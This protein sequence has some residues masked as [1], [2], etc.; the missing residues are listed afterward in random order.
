M[1]KKLIINKIKVF[2]IINL[3]LLSFSMLLF[4]LNNSMIF[5]EEPTKISKSSQFVIEEFI[6]KDISKDIYKIKIKV[7]KS[8][9][10]VESLTGTK[11]K[12]YTFEIG[13]SKAVYIN[14]SAKINLQDQNN[15]E[16]LIKTKQKIDSG[17][18]VFNIYSYKNEDQL[19]L[20]ATK[21]IE[22]PNRNSSPGKQPFIQV[23]NP[24]AG[25]SS[26][27]ITVVGENFGNDLDLI[28][29]SFGEIN[30]KE[31]EG[32]VDVAERKP[33]FLSPILNGS[34][35][36]LKFN[37]PSAK[38]IPNSFLFKQNL[39][40][41]IFVNGRPSDYKKLVILSDY[42]K[43][44]MLGFTVSLISIFHLFIIK[45]LKKK[46]YLSLLL[47]DKSTN[48]Y[49]LSRFQAFS[50]T[51]LLLGGYFY[52]TI[53]SGVLLGNG[54]IPEFNP[55]LIGLLSISYG[56]L[57]TAH[58]L[59][60]KKPKNEILKTPPLFNNLFSSGE[61][62][63]LPRL[64]LFSFTVVGIIIYLYNL[65]NSNPL[66]GLPDIPS[67]FL[68]L[69]GVSQTGYITGKF[70]S[71][72]IVI[73]QIKP[74]YIPVNQKDLRLH[75]LGAG[76]VQNMKILLDDLNEPISVDF[77]NSN[78]I[79]FLLPERTN[80]GFLSIN[81]LHNDFAPIYTENC[82]EIISFE[83]TKIPSYDNTSLIVSAGKIPPGTEL[84]LQKE[85]EIYRLRGNL[86]PDGKIDFKSPNLPPGNYSVSI[87]FKNE[88]N[89]EK[90]KM[91]SGLEVYTSELPKASLSSQTII[92][93]EDINDENEQDL[94]DKTEM[95]WYQ[96]GITDEDQEDDNTQVAIELDDQMEAELNIS[97]ISRTY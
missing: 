86:L 43:L 12:K 71:D 88:N 47:I 87:H 30:E 23:L 54:I 61:S 45:V 57:I 53:S 3:A 93:E 8:A 97:E 14:D 21:Q 91:N 85:D 52:I 75:I 15:V 63:D 35:Q 31:E 55:S 29:V 40:L 46:N 49:S 66:A 59:G 27:T 56:G 67:S 79:S 83:P 70:V 13:T 10:F 5:A 60:T 36:E 39:Y 17:L 20:E 95:P 28:S 34:T 77:I 26:D 84:V 94:P 11:T 25:K 96:S 1:L 64:Q 37:M 16:F 38:I 18:K 32:I 69:L 48:T 82:L 22:V 65:I 78:A 89:F 68:G 7:K 72:K 41:R 74:Y 90:I 19:T 42:W 76:F 9:D 4:Y 50:W 73:N 2:R 44:W 33:F 80:P 24:E 51:V 62:I 58:S 81:L 92:K 6:P